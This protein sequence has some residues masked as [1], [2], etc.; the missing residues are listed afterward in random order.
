[1]LNDHE[2][3]IEFAVIEPHPDAAKVHALKFHLNA[4]LLQLRLDVDGEFIQAVTTG[5]HERLKPKCSPIL[6]TD[7]VSIPV[8]PPSLFQKRVCLNWGRTEV[9]GAGLY[10][11]T[12]A[13]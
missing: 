9:A 6:F 2:G 5:W 3:D 7:S 1:M 12:D 11:E 4:N 8:M 10:D 13:A